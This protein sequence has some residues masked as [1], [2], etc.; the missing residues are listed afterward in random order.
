MDAPADVRYLEQFFALEDELMAEGAI[1]S[2]FVVITA[3][4][5]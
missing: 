3:V 2:D 4:R 5:D 1:G